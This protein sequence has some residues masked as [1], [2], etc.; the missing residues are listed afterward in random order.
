MVWGVRMDIEQFVDDRWEHRNIVTAGFGYIPPDPDPQG[1][2]HIG[3]HA[4]AERPKVAGLLSP[5]RLSSLAGT[6]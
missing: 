2:I 1:I 6:G 5:Y 4:D 3:I